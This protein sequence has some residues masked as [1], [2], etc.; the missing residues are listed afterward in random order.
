MSRTWRYVRRNPLLLVGV[1]MFAMLLL[2]WS[3]GPTFVDVAKARPISAMADQHPSAELPL[4]SDSVGRELLPNLLVGSL[5]TF[6]IGLTAGIIGLVVGTIL[7]FIGGYFGG[8]ADSVISTAADVALT[9]PAL[10][11]LVV[12]ASVIKEVLNVRNLALIVAALSWMRPAR[13]IRSQVLS[14]RERSYVE[15]ARLSG[16]NDWQIIVQELLPNL[17]PYLAATLVG[18]VA[19]AL[20]AAIGLEAMGLGPQTEPTLGMTIFWCNYY[21]A[22]LRGMWWWWAPPIIAILYVFAALF[23]ISSGLDELANPRLR[24]AR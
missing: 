18:A 16:M 10:A 17:L 20:L 4:G 2:F 7:G 22:L 12:I 5:Y 24:R 6:E 13:T 14:M 11:V 19:G 8:V 3:I 9:I 1:A 21:G 15:I 23:A